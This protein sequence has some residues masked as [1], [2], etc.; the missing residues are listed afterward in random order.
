MTENLDKVVFGE[1]A[2]ATRRRSGKQSRADLVGATLVDGKRGWVGMG[3]ARVSTGGRGRMKPDGK[4]G[5]AHGWCGWARRAWQVSNAAGQDCSCS[6]AVPS[7]SP[8]TALPWNVH[9]IPFPAITQDRQRQRWSRSSFVTT[10][11]CLQAAAAT[12][13]STSPRSMAAP[14]AFTRTPACLPSISLAAFASNSTTS[15]V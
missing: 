12:S 11:S 13:S 10:T 15:T 9:A 8:A 4:A 14:Y 1:H 6:C 3:N 7:S 5:A 2:P